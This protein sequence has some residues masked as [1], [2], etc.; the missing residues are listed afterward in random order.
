MCSFLSDNQY[1]YEDLIKLCVCT[2]EDN[3]CMFHLCKE[4]P[5]K[6]ELSSTLMIIFD[7]YDFDFDDDGKL[8][9]DSY[10]VISDHLLHDQTT[11]QFYFISD[12][13]NLHK[14]TQN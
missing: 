13:K 5:N 3:N 2:V 8:K 9:C 12:T 7:N 11:V 10:C 14:K 1:N 4:C 6:T